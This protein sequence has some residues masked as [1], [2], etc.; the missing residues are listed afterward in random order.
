MGI[1]GDRDISAATVGAYYDQITDLL[2]GDLGGSFHVGYWRDLP[3]ESPVPAAA[4][5]MTALMIDKIGVRAGQRVLD[6]GCGTGRPA[7]EL[8]QATGAEVLGVNVSRKQLALAESLAAQEGVAD[9]VR[10]EYADAM[11]LPYE[12]ESFDG[13][14]LFESLFHMPDQEKVLRRV[15]ELLRPGGRLVIADLVQLVPLTDEQ[16]AELA[17][18][19]T[20]NSVASIL[21]LDHYATL[22]PECGLALTELNDISED[23]LRATWRGIHRENEAWRATQPP[24]DEPPF[25]PAIDNGMMRLANTPEIGYA[26]VVAT[27]LS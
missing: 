5:H 14:W 6:I 27:K 23:A 4:R 26:L 21:P 22:L 2:D 8:A 17:G 18:C 10:F 24:T 19:W 15:S 7:I 11:E 1:R 13:A 20:A 16:N 25:D 12:A 3:P 9:R